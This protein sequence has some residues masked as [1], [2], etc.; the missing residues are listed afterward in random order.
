MLAGAAV[1]LGTLHFPPPGT[2][3]EELVLRSSR[4]VPQLYYLV[5]AALGQV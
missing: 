5:M 1:W 2:S 3:G 4:I